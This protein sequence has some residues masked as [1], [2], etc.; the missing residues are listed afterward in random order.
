VNTLGCYFVISLIC[1]LNSTVFSICN[2]LDKRKY[3]L[4][5]SFSNKII[6]QNEEENLEKTLKETKKY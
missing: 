2:F 5:D 6:I 1:F 3:C 4:F